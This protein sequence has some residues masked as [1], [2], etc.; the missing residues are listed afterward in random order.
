MKM[1]RIV[2]PHKELLTEILLQC[3]D[4]VRT[5]VNCMNVLA[6]VL[7][8]DK[9][10][11]GLRGAYLSETNVSVDWVNDFGVIVNGVYI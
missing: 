11:F 9:G 3:Y 4:Q 1:N 10:R 8:F 5:C 2:K 7:H 6:L